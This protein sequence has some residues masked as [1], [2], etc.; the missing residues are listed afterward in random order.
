MNLISA[1]KI[2]RKRKLNENPRVTE[3]CE[4]KH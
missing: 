4:R 1:K 2:G 3:G